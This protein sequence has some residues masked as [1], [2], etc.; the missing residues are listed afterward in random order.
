MP[1][2]WLAAL[3]GCAPDD[4]G[5][6]GID[7]CA[8]EP[9]AGN[10]V[11]E[12]PV[13]EPFLADPSVVGPDESPDGRFHLFANG[14]TGIHEFV[15]DDGLAWE[16]V[17]TGLFGVGAVRPYLLLA[18]GTWHLYY[19]WFPGGLA[20]SELRVVTSP[21]LA[22]WSE[23]AT[24]LTA[25]LP[26]EVEADRRT[27]SNPS[28]ERGPDGRWWLY[29]SASQVFLPV[30]SYIWEPRYVS[31]AFADA[32]T[33][34]F[35]KHG[36]PLFGPDPDLPYRN[37][38][39]G[40]LKRVTGTPGDALWAL[41]NGIFDDGGTTGSSIR[42]VRSDDGLTWEE[43]CDAPILSPDGDGWDTAFVY[44]FD[45]RVSAGGARIWYNAR[46]GWGD[47]VERIGTALLPRR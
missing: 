39:A 14:L 36:A 38:G 22:D 23:P 20:T 47:G 3:A 27:V 8:A 2:P 43:A 26:F 41:T 17:R 28:V 18:D 13:T 46:D 25:E 5:P 1:R 37:L 44:A 15:S 35:E 30:T 12:S 40:S 21:D 29:Y 10:P 34:P 9:F 4:P 7:W 33:G 24:I 19:E 42:A 6:G 31:V 32:P 16:V 11:L 45:T